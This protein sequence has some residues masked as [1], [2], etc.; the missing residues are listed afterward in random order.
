MNK[1]AGILIALLLSTVS[2]W[3]D[4]ITYLSPQL[5]FGM[6]V[7]RS[8]NVL[9]V[10]TAIKATNGN[11]YGWHLYNNAAATRYFKFYNIATA[12]IG[13]TTPF[14]TISI[15]AGAGANVEFSMGITFSTAISMAC[16]TG[17]ADADAAAPTANDCV[18]NIFFK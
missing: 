14:L 16:T 13:T 12:T 1:L 7:F 11:L 4:G 8:V 10:S 6:S 15:P 18:A 9:N 17:V 2:A 3:A 5:K